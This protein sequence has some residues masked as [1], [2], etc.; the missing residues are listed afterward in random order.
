MLL[1]SS[2]FCCA[3][4]LCRE[5]YSWAVQLLKLQTRQGVQ[6]A[7]RTTCLTTPAAS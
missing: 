6:K 3:R 2:S 7:C 1:K 5:R 4:Q